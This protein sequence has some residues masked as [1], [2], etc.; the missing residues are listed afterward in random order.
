MSG[1][2]NGQDPN[3]I[4]RGLIQ[5]MTIGE[6]PKDEDKPKFVVPG[7]GAPVYTRN[8]VPINATSVRLDAQG[9]P[10]DPTVKVTRTMPTSV[11]IPFAV[12]IAPANAEEVPVGN[13][14][15]TKATLTVLD[16][17]GEGNALFAQVKNATDVIMG[18][19]T[20]AIMYR[21]PPVGLGPI[22]VYTLIAFARQET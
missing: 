3:V 17:D 1:T 14:R 7:S 20:Y 18:G 10:L 13:F 15:P 9:R 21:L 12:E 22:T 16:E 8:G 11:Q 4:R 19:D 2:L 5:A 6:P